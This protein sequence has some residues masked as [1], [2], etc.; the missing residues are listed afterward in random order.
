MQRSHRVATAIPEISTT[1]A[2]VVHAKHSSTRSTQVIALTN[3][4][5]HTHKHTQW[6][7]CNILWVLKRTQQL[8]DRP[9]EC[10]GRNHLLSEDTKI[11]KIM[12]V[13]VA[14]V[15]LFIL[16]NKI[17]FVHFLRLLPH[18]YYWCR[19]CWSYAHIHNIHVHTRIHISFVVWFFFA[20]FFFFNIRHEYHRHFHG[21]Y[22]LALVCYIQVK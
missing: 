19:L 18:R 17:H 5:T 1:M 14:F 7:A 15:I 12:Q 16:R 10:W 11:V 3:P 4:N 6:A 8:R 22:V 13:P 2:R 20:V 21:T 9:R